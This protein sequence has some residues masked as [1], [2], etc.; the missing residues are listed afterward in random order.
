MA[1]RQHH[2]VMALAMIPSGFCTASLAQTANG[3][4]CGRLLFKSKF[5]T[6]SHLLARAPV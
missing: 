5:G 6:S 2:G 3:G 4:R 1:A